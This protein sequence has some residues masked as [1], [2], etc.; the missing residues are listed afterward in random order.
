MKTFHLCG[1]LL[2]AVMVVGCSNKS[3]A[4]SLA[5]VE[6]AETDAVADLGEAGD[7]VGDVL[8]FANPVFDADNTE[9]VGTDNG[10]CLRTA[11]GSAWECH[12]ILTLSD[13]QITVDGPFYDTADSV[14]AIT[15]GTG[16]YSEARGEMALHARNAQGTEY[17]F[18][19]T[20]A[21]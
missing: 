1:M 18:T 5:V 3:P 20:I 19:Y 11:V 10:Y 13:G 21:Q 9:Q 8:T 6:H 2:G 14:L 4:T 16:A 7:S 15:G 17:D 12:W